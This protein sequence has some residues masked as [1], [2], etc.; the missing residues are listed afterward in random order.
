MII[1]LNEIIKNYQGD[2]ENLQ[3]ENSRLEQ[4]KIQNMSN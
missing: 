4:E 2:M 1:K 3:K